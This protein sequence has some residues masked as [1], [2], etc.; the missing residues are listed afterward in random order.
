MA[1]SPEDKNPELHD[2]FGGIG[3]DLPKITGRRPDL[4]RGVVVSEQLPLPV[5]AHLN[6]K[7]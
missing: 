3:R 7:R 2:D 4:W 5:A 1:T 6:Q